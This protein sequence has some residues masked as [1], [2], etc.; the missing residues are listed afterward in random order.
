MRRQL[1]HGSGVFIALLIRWLYSIYGG[2]QVPAAILT[3]AISAG[4]GISY[5]YLRN[6]NLP[7]LTRIID[8][9]E[10]EHDK[11]FPGKGALRFFTGALFTI[12]IFRG[13]PE[14]VVAS[15]MVLALG[16]SVSTLAGVAFGKRKIPYNKDKS[17]EGSISGIFAAV[18]GLLVF[19]SFAL[20][21][22]ITASFVGMVVESL[23][24]GID[25][26]LTVPVFTGLSIWL[27][28]GAIII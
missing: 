2:W 3:L 17:I 15:V 6:V 14:I 1:L 20:P 13:S 24:L 26:N 8:G 10:R 7:L 18:I 12:L 19:T 28:T 4:Y 25:D 5:L 16:D 11:G 27:L 23:P 9:A 21:V 22:I